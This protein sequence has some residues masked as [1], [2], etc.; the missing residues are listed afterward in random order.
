R[1][2]ALILERAGQFLGAGAADALDRAARHAGFFGDL[3]ALRGDDGAGGFVAVVAAERR[4]R[5]PAVGPLRAVLVGDVEQHE[6]ADD[7]GA[8]FASHVVVPSTV[9][10]PALEQ[11][12]AQIGPKY[13]R[14]GSN[15]FV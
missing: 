14:F 15:L 11:G 2:R 12:V 3:A 5:H 7:A 8:W 6:F 9:R 4:G 1:L 13:K 10:R